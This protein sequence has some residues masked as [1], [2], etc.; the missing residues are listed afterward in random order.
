VSESKQCRKCGEEKP[1]S[2]FGYDRYRDDG[3]TKNCKRC[4]NAAAKAWR[5]A[6]RDIVRINDAARRLALGHRPRT[7]PYDLESDSDDDL[8][9][10][11][12]DSDD[13]DDLESDSDDDLADTKPIA[14][15]E[16]P[17]H[18]YVIRFANDMIKVG[19]A[20]NVTARVRSHANEGVR[21]GNNAVEHWTSQVIERVCLAETALIQWCTEQ[22]GA[23]SHFGREWFTGLDYGHTVRE[24]TH[25]GEPGVAARTIADRAELTRVEAALMQMQEARE[26]LMRSL[27]RCG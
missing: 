24:A 14:Q 7:A 12:G 22:P 3:L 26:R 10:L 18:L 4:N 21:H 9:D 16:T 5:E 6:N 27:R 15:R 23:E 8:D 19:R 11:D 2:D 25:L 20:S 1:L 17:G 13:L